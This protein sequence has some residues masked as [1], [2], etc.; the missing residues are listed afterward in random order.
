MAV[1]LAIVT[2]VILIVLVII[3]DMLVFISECA[4]FDNLAPQHVIACASSSSSEDAALENA[5]ERIQNDLEA[6]F[7]KNASWVSVEEIGVGV[8]FANLKTFRCTLHFVPWPL[9]LSG[10]PTNLEHSCSLS[11]DSYVPG[12]LL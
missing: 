11:V 4:R 8:P 7:N 2:P 9:N 10:A 3:F 12:K 6:E 5:R 1:E